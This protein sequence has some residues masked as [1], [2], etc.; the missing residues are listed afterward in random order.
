MNRMSAVAALDSTPMLA[1]GLPVQVHHDRT[2]R[3]KIIDACGMTCTFCH[4]EGTPVVADNLG[5]SRGKM[6]ERGHSGRVSIYLATNG[7]TFLPATI[8]PDDAFA[9]ALV[10]LREALSL[11]ELHLTGGEPSLHPRLAEIVTAGAS[12]GLRVC[13]TSNGE[14]G[15]RVMVDCARAGLYR[16]NFSIFGTTATELAQVQEARFADVQR[17][18]KKIRALRESVRLTL[19]HGVG[20]SA[21]IVVPNYDHA[22]RVRRLMDEYAP[23][24]SVRLLNSL[25]DGIE[26]IEAIER[27]LADLGAVPTGHH[28]TAGASGWRTSYQMPGGRVVWFKQIR[29]VRLP[30]TCAGCRFNNGTDCQEGYYGVRLYRDR[31]G[32]F[33]VGVCIQRMDLCLPV[34]EFIGS[35]LCREIIA[36][37]DT[38]YVQLSSAS[39]INPK[40][41]H[42]ADRV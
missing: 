31:S 40:G 3:V 32:G 36:L 34:E 21:N 2:L 22:T 28:V 4:N 13:M 29:P 26:S 16:V 27:I 12:A 39:R 37:R 41:N 35:D 1:D 33:Q 20:A 8:A 42:D 24:L 11:E 10:R 17:A 6:T 19:A 30:Q 25:D 18:E 9:S 38:D 15:A 5:T 7:A 23:E 14:N